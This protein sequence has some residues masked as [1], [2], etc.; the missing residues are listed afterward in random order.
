MLVDR[1]P[2]ALDLF[3]GCG[4]LTLGLKQA[5]FAVVGAL[6]ISPLAAATYARNH[7]EVAVWN[8]DIR[9]AQTTAI[10]RAL[11]LQKG[12]LDLLAGCPPCEGFSSLRT[13]NGGRRVVD[14]RNEL[15]F[16]LLRFVRAFKPKAVMMENVP[17]LMRN[18]RFV[19]LRAELERLGYRCSV[20]VLNAADYNVPQRR[21]RMILLAGFGSAIQFGRPARSRKTVRDSIADLAHT[22]KTRRDTLHRETERRS[23]KVT[24]LIRRVP[25]DGGSRVNLPERFALKCHQSCTGFKDVYG[26]MRWDD[27][28]P[29]I[30]GGFVNP[31]KGR[32][33]HPSKNRT[34]TLREAAVLQTFPRRYFFS[35]ARGKFAAAEMIGNALPPEFVRRHALSVSKFVRTVRTR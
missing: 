26:R 25:K 18:R 12:D 35:L 29:T 8:V 22:T 24:S 21:R 19:A 11:N 34:I 30:T 16:Q 5:G 1:E 23:P 2:T 15:V 14:D 32:F 3:A 33:L 9:R 6:E 7:P 31:S 27:V 20:G 17:G 28:S 4:G 13:L 10:L